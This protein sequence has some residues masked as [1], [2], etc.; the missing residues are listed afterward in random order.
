MEPQDPFAYEEQAPAQA[1]GMPVTTTRMPNTPGIMDVQRKQQEV[2]QRQAQALE[3]A[4][5]AQQ[6]G[7]EEQQRIMAGLDKDVSELDQMRSSVEQKFVEN[8]QAEMTAI[9]ARRA[10]LEK[11]EPKSFWQKA[12]TGSKIGMAIAV[13]AGGIG[14][15]LSGARTNAAVEAMNRAIDMDLAQQN[16]M[17]DRQLASL[18][19]RKMDLKDKQVLQNRLLAEYDVRKSAALGQARRMLERAALG[20]QN[21]QSKAILQQKLAEID[22]SLL[23]A[24]QELQEKLAGRVTQ[25]MM[26]GG[27]PAQPQQAQGGGETKES[28]YQALAASLPAGST[29]LK[30][31]E[32][33]SK[34]AAFLL[35]N[36]RNAQQLEDIEKQMTPEEFETLK[37]A[38]STFQSDVAATQV[39]GIGPVLEVAGI[40]L[41]KTPKERFEKALPG[42]GGK[43]YQALKQFANDQVRAVS[44]AAIKA[45]EEM[46]EMIKFMPTPGT[47][48]EDRAGAAVSRRQV[49]KSH[50]LV[51]GGTKPLFFEKSKK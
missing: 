30:L 41:G 18:D 7:A 9:Q 21:A 11:V 51:S 36:E 34:S 49:L 48:Y 31:N 6:A 47:N 14:Q 19:Q 38:V 22:S 1:P 2:A 27:G 50:R 33:Q 32:V 23:Q 4:S 25:Q 29:P 12:D 45:D 8:M 44:G 17:I 28:A 35:R 13:L 20:T 40:Y 24:D 16:K 37:D 42:K 26:V 39:P 5:R 15:G 46:T 10:E 3:Q 43:Y